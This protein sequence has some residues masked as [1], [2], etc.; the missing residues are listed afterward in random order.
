MKYFLAMMFGGMCGWI[1][2]YFVVLS[3]F[4]DE[5]TLVK[6][7]GTNLAPTAPDTILF[8]VLGMVIG[9]VIAYFKKGK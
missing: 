9:M 5:S 1:T 8:T 6:F 3:R 2:G 4:E 7:L